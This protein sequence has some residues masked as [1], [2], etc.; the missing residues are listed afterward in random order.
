MPWMTWRGNSGRAYHGAARAAA[1]AAGARRLE[2]PAEAIPRNFHQSHV[3]GADVAAVPGDVRPP[4]PRRRCKD[5]PPHSAQQIL[6]A[7]S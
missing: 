2:P 6:L 7:T 4:R 3:G 1:A 5:P